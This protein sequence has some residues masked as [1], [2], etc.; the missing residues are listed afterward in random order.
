MISG[1][2]EEIY[3]P[4]LKD[5]VAMTDG[6]YKRT[7]VLAMEH[8]MLESL[9]FSLTFPTCF[10]FLERFTR[11]IGEEGDVLKYGHFLLDLSLLELRFLRFAPSVLAASSIYLSIKLRQKQSREQQ[12]ESVETFLCKTLGF[13]DGDLRECAR[14][15]LES[16]H[17]L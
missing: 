17:T 10:R 13:E 5:Y 8:H 16:S 15:L 9:Q 4:E 3:P 6:A 7:D 11:E 1:K 14:S 2:Y 12:G